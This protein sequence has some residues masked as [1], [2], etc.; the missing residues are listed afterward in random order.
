MNALI[1]RSTLAAALTLAN[2]SLPAAAS[3][4][5]N[6][7]GTET[8]ALTPFSAIAV[9]GPWHVVVTAQGERPLELSGPRKEMANVET[10]VTGDT[11]IVRPLQ[12]KGWHFSFSWSKPAPLTV[13]I[14]APHL[15]SLKA[16]GSGDVEL[17]QFH[18]QQLALSTSG[19]GDLR[20]SGDARELTVR[21]G[22]SG[23]VNLRAMMAGKL[24]LRM[25]GS[26][27]VSAGGVEQD[28]NAELNGSGDLDLND[29]RGGRVNAALHGSG[30]MHVRGGSRELRA[31]LFGSGDLEACEL[32]AQA[33]TAVLRGSG[34]ACVAGATRQFEAEVHGSG[35]LTASANCEQV[36][37][38]MNGSGQVTLAGK[39]DKL[40]AQLSGSGDLNA[41]QLSAGQAEVVVRGPGTAMVNVKTADKARLL[42]FDRSGTYE[43][44]H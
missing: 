22:G 25:S 35:D 32:Q 23:N 34:D 27:D 38:T 15:L 37:L 36:K 18:G 31:E 7:V 40:H 20:A 14:T 30:T 17:E 6:T 33:V 12:R 42:T 13:H 24:N 8:R 3:Q 43:R 9:E 28:L 21:T 4:P 19:S 26:G 1:Y 16:S 10:V 41:R 39:T 44:A 11:L 5:D 29:V 2:A